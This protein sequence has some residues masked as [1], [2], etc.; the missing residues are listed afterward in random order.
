MVLFRTVTGAI[1]LRQQCYGARAAR[2]T[3]NGPMLCNVSPGSLPR[4]G[5][6]E[7][8]EMTS[9]RKNAVPGET[10]HNI[11]YRSFGNGW[12]GSNYGVQT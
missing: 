1:G 6:A 4:S 3:D 2:T 5:R 12:L 7:E 10:L 11:Y 9:S 8:D